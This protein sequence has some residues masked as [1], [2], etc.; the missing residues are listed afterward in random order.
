MKHAIPPIETIRNGAGDTRKLV[1]TSTQETI[2]VGIREGTVRRISCGI[3]HPNGVEV[4]VLAEKDYDSPFI[5]P[6]SIN[7]EGILRTHRYLTTHGYPTIPVMYGNEE[8]NKL[9]MTDLTEDGKYTVISDADWHSMS[10]EEHERRGKFADSQEIFTIENTDVLADALSKLLIKCTEEGCV[11]GDMAKDKPK[12]NI[13]FII[14]DPNTKKG[15]IL[16]GDI[17]HIYPNTQQPKKDI[18]LFNYRSIHFFVESINKRLSPET[19]IP[20]Q[21]IQETYEQLV[22]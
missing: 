5:K 13:F 12:R 9:Y 17:Y 14:L 10:D 3:E 11:L 8:N 18:A 21:P 2:G 7:F 15:K 1:K 4:A 19:Q 16:L 6:T 22:K 20:I